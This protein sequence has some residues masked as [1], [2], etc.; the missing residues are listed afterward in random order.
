MLLLSIQTAATPKTTSTKIFL[1]SV[2]ATAIV[3]KTIEKKSKQ[4][5]QV[6]NTHKLTTIHTLAFSYFHISVHLVCHTSSGLR[7]KNYFISI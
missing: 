1:V 6:L 5:A 7:Y 3:T 2:A 4:T